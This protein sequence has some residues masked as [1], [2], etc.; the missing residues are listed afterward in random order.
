MVRKTTYSDKFYVSRNG[1]CLE[2]LGTISYQGK[3]TLASFN[4]P[5]TMLWLSLGLKIHPQTLATLSYVETMRIT[6]I[7]KTGQVGNS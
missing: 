7:H 1:I 4:L 6:N 2:V 5:R 3:F